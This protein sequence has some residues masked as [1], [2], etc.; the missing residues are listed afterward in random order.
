[1]TSCDKKNYI[2]PSRFTFSKLLY[3]KLSKIL[4][5]FLLFSNKM[6]IRTG[7]HKMLVEIS[8]R[9]DPDQTTSLA[10]PRGYKT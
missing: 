8:N 3:G 6:V 4:N 1:M 5:T 9:E 7:I 10:R 2:Q